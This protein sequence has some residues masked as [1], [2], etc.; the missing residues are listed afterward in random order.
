MN[1][2]RDWRERIV[3]FYNDFEGDNG[4][5][6][7]SFYTEG[8][9]FE[10]PLERI[11]GREALKS[12]YKHLYKGLSSIKFE[13]SETCVAEEERGIALFWDMTFS[14]RSLKKGEDIVVPGVSYFKLEEEMVSYH[15]DV[16]DTSQMVYRHVPVLGW[17]IRSLE[18]R[19]RHS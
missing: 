4:D 12:Y 7:D 2:M 17:V 3:S 6:L 5:L 11:E 18:R 10:D 14:T 13:F 16:F 8:V 15:R 9:I 19:L 1:S